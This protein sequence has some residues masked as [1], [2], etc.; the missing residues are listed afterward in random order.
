M[1]SDENSIS[2][3]SNEQVINVARMLIVLEEPSS[4]V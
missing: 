2:A 1:V 3:V 4:D